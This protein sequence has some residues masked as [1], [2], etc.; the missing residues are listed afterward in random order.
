MVLTVVVPPTEAKYSR[1]GRGT[2]R[3]SIE[4]LQDAEPLDFNAE[5][6]SDD[7]LEAGSTR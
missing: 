6:L 3:D 5:T 4:L 7:P 1:T 2:E